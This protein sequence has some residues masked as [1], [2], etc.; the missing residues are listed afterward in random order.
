MYEVYFTT[1]FVKTMGS[2][3]RRQY[4]ARWHDKTYLDNP[5][6][7]SLCWCSPFIVS[8]AYVERQLANMMLEVFLY[9]CCRPWWSNH[10]IHQ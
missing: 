1:N 9:K 5:T 2:H 6:A 3:V 10:G 4:D 7:S 8:E